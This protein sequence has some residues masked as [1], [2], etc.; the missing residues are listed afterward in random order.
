M[1]R[2]LRAAAQLRDN[3]DSWLEFT[4]LVLIDPPGTGWSRTVEADD[5]GF[6]RALLARN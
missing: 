4:D 1:A 2:K 6:F 3:P 5:T